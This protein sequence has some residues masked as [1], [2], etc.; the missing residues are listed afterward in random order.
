MDW[1]PIILAL[2][3]A[4]PPTIGAFLAYR[5]AGQAKTE[6]TN[7]KTVAES[8]HELVNGQ[9]KQLVDAVASA[10]GLKGELAGRDFAV[11]PVVSAVASAAA[12]EDRLRAL[13]EAAVEHA[14]SA[15][16]AGDAPMPVVIASTVAP[17]PVIVQEPPA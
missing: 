10:A 14:L 15:R 16:R 13:V 9:S 2:I 1:Q 8:T 17:V 3:A 11:L 4:A 12:A 5:K 6:A 7:A